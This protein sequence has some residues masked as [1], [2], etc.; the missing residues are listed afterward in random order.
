[1]FL[2]KYY[3]NILGTGNRVAH[4]NNEFDPS[5]IFCRFRA[6]P[7]PLETFSHVFFE[8]PQVNAIIKK[9]FDK[10]LEPELDSSKYFTGSFYETEYDNSTI[11]II[12]DSLRYNIWQSRLN[13]IAVSFYTIEHET[14]TFL[15]QLANSSK[16][17]DNK[18]KISLC[19]KANR[20]NGGR[21]RDGD[22]GDP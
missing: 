16:V 9:F 12:L 11:S 10:Y 5:C 21:R 2:F 4:F 13:K 8:C 7:A 17:I 19:L 14:L 15:T 6:R 1:M 20:G 18:L 3:S 22:G